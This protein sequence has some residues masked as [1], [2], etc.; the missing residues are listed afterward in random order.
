MKY[1]SCYCC[2]CCC[3]CCYY[4]ID[5]SLHLATEWDGRTSVGGG[6]RGVLAAAK[7]AC[8][9]WPKVVCC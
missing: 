8:V 7:R 2:Y 1:G 3:F 5:C 6:R 4:G 9:F